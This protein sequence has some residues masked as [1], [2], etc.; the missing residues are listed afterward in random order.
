MPWISDIEQEMNALERLK[1]YCHLDQEAPSTLPTDPD[2][3]KWPTHG[4]I[5]FRDVEFKYRSELPLVLRGLTF[6][7]KPGE[8]VGIVGRTGAG[9][10]SMLQAIERTVELAGGQICI[11]GVDLKSLGL[12]TVRT[13]AAWARTTADA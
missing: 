8:N 11:D 2:A 6:D 9:K 3:S 4:A 1:H 5:S 10:S 7:V 13:T 12:H